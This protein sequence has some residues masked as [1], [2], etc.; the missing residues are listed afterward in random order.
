MVVGSDLLRYLFPVRIQCSDRYL[1]DPHSSGFLDCIQAL[2]E[3]PIDRRFRNLPRSLD[4]LTDNRSSTARFYV[5]AKQCLS[6]IA[7]PLRPARETASPLVACSVDGFMGEL[8]R[9]F[10]DR[11][12]IDR[13]ND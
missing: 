9:R 3:S 8:A 12:G 13:V 2:S 7:L 10:F 4:C 11:S 5:V 1:C 6:R